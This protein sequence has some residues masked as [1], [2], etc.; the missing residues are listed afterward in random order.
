MRDCV[1]AI[2]RRGSGASRYAD[3]DV[4]Y[5]LAMFWNDRDTP[6]V[7]MGL[8]LQEFIDEM[9]ARDPVVRAPA[10]MVMIARV[11]IL[12]RGVANAFNVRLKVAN[13]WRAHAETPSSDE[14]NR[15]IICST[16]GEREGE[17]AILRGVARA[18]EEDRDVG[19][20]RRRGRI[21]FLDP[22]PSLSARR[23]SAGPKDAAGTTSRHKIPPERVPSAE[24]RVPSASSAARLQT[25]TRASVS[26]TRSGVTSSPAPSPSPSPSPSSKSYSRSSSR[27][28]AD[29]ARRHR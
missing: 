26:P 8:N 23:T 19:R 28:F 6:D 1:R 29:V 13:A 5:R 24:C 3:K 11:S 22:S 7:T 18:R 27:G 4:A 21:I 2:R 14:P 12:L 9:E 10:D 16:P 15:T 20:V 25:S 17:K